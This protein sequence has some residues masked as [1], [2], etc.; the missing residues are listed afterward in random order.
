MP[1]LESAKRLMRRWLTSILFFIVLGLGLGALIAIPVIPK[2]N[3]ATITI[4]GE[5][6]GQD[7]TDDILDML[8]NA[9][10]DD[11]IKAVVLQIDSPGGLVSSTE[12]IYLDVLRLRQQ[13]PV[14]ASIGMVGAS[15][16]Y[17]KSSQPSWH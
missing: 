4:S 14:V 6:L 9:R 5:I 3:V 12:Q 2:P 7:Y 1:K 16:G 11:S 8:R 10:N 13:K 15:G 17:R